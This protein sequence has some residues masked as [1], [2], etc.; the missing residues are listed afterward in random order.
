MSPR[1]GSLQTTHCFHLIRRSYLV[2]LPAPSKSSHMCLLKEWMAALL[3]TIF[4][5]LGTLHKF[6][7]SLWVSESHLLCEIAS[8]H[9]PSSGET[10]SRALPQQ[11]VCMPCSIYLQV[12][13]E[14]VC[15]PHSLM[16]E[17]ALLIHGF[18][19]PKRMTDTWWVLSVHAAY[20]W[21][22]LISG[23]WRG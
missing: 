18:P 2:Q 4:P 17:T 16:A 11:S 3:H 20:S 7:T 13:F 14:V 10:H 1:F 23:R 6:I 22:S 8:P 21:S 9:S 15:A 5:L 19:G 12:P